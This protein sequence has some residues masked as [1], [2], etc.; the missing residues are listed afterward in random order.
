MEFTYVG[1]GIDAV[2]I[3]NFYNEEQ[4]K[5]IMSELAWLTKPAIMQPPEMLSSAIDPVKGV[6]TSKNGIFLEEVF[7]NWKHSALIKHAFDGFKRE[8]VIDKLVSYNGLFKI[9]QV[10][11][12]RTHLVSYYQNADYY[13]SHT[14]KTVFTILN[15]FHT[16]PKKFTGGDVVLHSYKEQ[17]LATVEVKHNRVVVIA[18]CTPHEVQEINSHLSDPLSGEGRYCNAIFLYVDGTN[19]NKPQQNDSN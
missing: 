12:S 11:N 14:D 9:L 5:E 15:W 4:L 13:K 19:P 8:D 18:G 3:D 10:C 17:K 6:L 16:T 7:A 1:D 2:V